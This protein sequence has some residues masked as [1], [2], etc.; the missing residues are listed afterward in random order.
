MAIINIEENIAYSKKFAQRCINGEFG[1]A[2]KIDYFMLQISKFLLLKESIIKKVSDKKIIFDYNNGLIYYNQI[3]R[4]VDYVRK[5]GVLK[6]NNI[7]VLIEPKTYSNETL[8]EYIRDF[9]KIRDSF[10]HGAYKIDPDNGL[11]ILN[12]NFIAKDEKNSFEIK[13][14]LPIEFLEIFTYLEINDFKNGEI[15]ER[16]R[17]LK[18][19]Q[20]KKTRLSF[21]YNR[22]VN[23]VLFY[24]NINNYNDLKMDKTINDEIQKENII[25]NIYYKPTINN[26]FTNNKNIFNDK[27]IFKY[28]K[29]LSTLV[30]Y[31]LENPYIRE[32][33][34]ESILKLLRY[35]DL[36]DKEKTLKHKSNPDKQYLTKLKEVIKEISLI[37]GFT[38][39]DNLAMVSVYNYMQTFLSFKNE[40]IKNNY[41]LKNFGKLKMSKIHIVDVKNKSYL[42]KK[43]AINRRVKGFIKKYKNGQNKNEVST[44][45]KSLINYLI[46]SLAF[47]NKEII[48]YIRNSVDHGNITQIGPLIELTDQNDQTDDS[49]INFKCAATPEDYFELIKTIDDGVNESDFTINDLLNE[50]ENVLEKETF[51][52]LKEIII[53]NLGLINT[54][55]QEEEKKL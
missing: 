12:N 48:T 26:K 30:D 14:S 13:C 18:I 24:N 39:E 35:L 54:L 27:Y 25:N 52:K 10:A 1:K 3:K 49:T 32:E 22:G 2:D 16:I 51:I 41:L 38:S 37:L 7:E 28:E 34:K 20:I 9:H 29:Y 40:D 50:L 45:L 21:R 44:A 19:E 6:S 42:E 23:R 31:A 47:L 15:L 33:T 17:E 55:N 4:I 8:K 36:I 53:E 11:I 46:E 43:I 5:N